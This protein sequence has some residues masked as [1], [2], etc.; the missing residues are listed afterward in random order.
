M[1]QCVLSLQNCVNIIKNS[2]NH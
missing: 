2:G 1:Q